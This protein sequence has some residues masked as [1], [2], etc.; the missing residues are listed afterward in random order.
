[1]KQ[2]SFSSINKYLLSTFYVVGTAGHELNT[3]VNKTA[4]QKPCI[5]EAHILVEETNDN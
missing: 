2:S 1:M 5:H 4:L 3:E